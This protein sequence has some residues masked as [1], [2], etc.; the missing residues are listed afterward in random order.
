[1]ETNLIVS[2]SL[3][4]GL[5]VFWLKVSLT[6]GSHHINQTCVDEKRKHLLHHIHNHQEE[7]IL[8]S[9]E[10]RDLGDE[11]THLIRLLWKNPKDT[12]TKNYFLG[13]NNEVVDIHTHDAHLTEVKQKEYH[14]KIG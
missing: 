6:D 13:E 11:D 2:K 10:I 12:W 8:L 9:G 3:L 14:I 4:L 1:M 7:D 5:F